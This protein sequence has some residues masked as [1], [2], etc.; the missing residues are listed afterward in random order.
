MSDP[1]SHVAIKEG[2]LENFKRCLV[3]AGF[4]EGKPLPKKVMDV[5]EQRDMIGRTCFFLA[6]EESQTDIIDFLL[7]SKQFPTLNLFCKDTFEGD[8]PLH[9]AVR[10]GNH[11]LV[12]R[13]F[14]MNKDKC[15]APNFK[16]HN[17]LFLATKMQ[18]LQMLELFA[19]YKYEALKKRD[20]LGENP[21]FE[22]ARNGN[23]DIFNWFCGNNEFFKARG[24]QN[25]K[26]QTIEHIVCMEK[27]LPIVDE[28]RPR[29]DI[30]D[31][32][33]NLPLYYTLQNN[34]VPMLEKYFHST[35]E[36]FKLRNYKYETI[37]H[38]CAKHHSLDALKQLLGRTV[39]LPQLLKKDYVGNTPIHVAAKSGSLELLKF[40]CTA[41]T[42][43]FLKMQ[44]DFGFTPLEAAQEKYHLME[45]S[46]SNRKAEAKTREEAQALAEKEPEVV[47]KIQ[48]IKDCTKFLI[49][50]KEFVTEESWGERFDL[51][52]PLYL[53]QVADTNM[54]IFMGMPTEEDKQ[55]SEHRVPKLKVR[56]VAQD[57]ANVV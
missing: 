38:V 51:P 28:I 33:G 42:P 14:E 41:A 47:A 11:E 50:S 36:Y 21:L 49:H 16:G 2:S 46:F 27:Q 45:E 54:R 4:V 44:N 22:C 55:V 34:D 53:E 15:L 35:K 40:L 52:L 6:V 20:Y 24:M 30:V 39:F 1:E 56:R 26:G 5:L 17:P 37:F 23:E 13:L 12:K 25:Y 48:K 7:D 19:E 29:P 31:Y 9:M 43:N 32:Y 8:I 18:D 57:P 3:D 10:K